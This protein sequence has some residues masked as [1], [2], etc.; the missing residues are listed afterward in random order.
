VVGK[1][2]QQL[3]GA[4]EPGTQASAVLLNELGKSA[5]G[6]LARPGREQSEG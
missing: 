6:G 2:G 3:P 1:G 4:E 5:R